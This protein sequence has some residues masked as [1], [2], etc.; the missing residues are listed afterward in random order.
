MIEALGEDGLSIDAQ[1]R[2]C[3]IARR[4]F[5]EGDWVTLDGNS[6]AV[7]AGRLEVVAERP[8]SAVA[9]IVGWR[10]SQSAGPPQAAADCKP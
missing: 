9:S 8:E 5:A 4:D 2:T 1:G 7:Y 3:R 10:A 6:G